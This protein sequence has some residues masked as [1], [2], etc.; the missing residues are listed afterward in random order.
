VVGGRKALVCST[1]KNAG[2]DWMPVVSCGF[3]WV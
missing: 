3:P 2:V 1:S